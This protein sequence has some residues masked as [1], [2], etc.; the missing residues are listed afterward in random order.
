MAG[1]LLGRHDHR[2]PL[3]LLPGLT[4]D[5]RIWQPVLEHLERLDPGRQILALDLPAHGGSPSQLPHNNDH[6]IELLRR[7]VDEA[8][9]REPVVVG[10]SM[11]GGIASM[12]AAHHPVSGVVN[13]DAPPVIAPFVRLIQSM[14]DPDTGA[15]V[16]ATWAIME[17]SFRTDLLSD[18]MRQLVAS[19]SHPDENL[20]LSYWH[21]LLHEP[22]ERAEDVISI[23]MSAVAARAVPYQLIC[24]TQPPPEAIERIDRLTSGGATVDVWDGCGHFPHLAHPARFAQRLAAT[25]TPGATG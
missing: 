8:G 5:R 18:A 22:A 17:Q 13:V 2:A 10:H 19:T 23:E 4:F 11:A 21:D 12:Y 16:A 20:I 3:V 14:I 25:A 1:D 6:L 15:G 9:L 24:G 7:A